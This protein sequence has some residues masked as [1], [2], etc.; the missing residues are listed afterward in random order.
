MIAR[1]GERGSLSITDIEG[2][3][4]LANVQV[5]YITAR[6]LSVNVVITR[7]LT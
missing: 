6:S 4:Y 5:R 7:V 1:E 3:S 2:G